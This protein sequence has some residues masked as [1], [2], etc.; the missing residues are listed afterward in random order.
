MRRRSM[1]RRMRT[2]IAFL[3]PFLTCVLA[4]FEAIGQVV[5][6]AVDQD[7]TNA[8]VLYI[9]SC[10][11][12]HGVDGG[13]GEGPPLARP[14]LPRA[15]DDET[16]MRIMEDGIPG[17]GMPGTWWLSAVETEQ[18]ARYIRS[19]APSRPEDVETLPGDA[20]RG[21]AIYERA[22]CGACHTVRGFGTAR[23]PDLTTV[24]ARRGAGYLREAIVD[25]AAALP[26]GLTAVQP[27]FVDYLLVRVVDENGDAVLGMRLNED[28]Y[29]IQL[30]DAAGVVRSF[31]KP[32]LRALERQFDRS[33]M[34]GYGETLTAAEIDDLVAYLATLTSRPRGIS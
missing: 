1:A 30:K 24:G 11:R 32:G 19:L 7:L 14:Q 10:A 17:T 31:Y 28:S 29:T 2:D 15:P 33:L 13:G 12:C 20:I 6:S 16:L 34:Q 27:G 18:I 5:P 21:R 23:G 26:R 9:A 4:P 8:R 25:P 22:G 3:I